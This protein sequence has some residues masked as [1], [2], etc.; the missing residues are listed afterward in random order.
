MNLI[1]SI[2]YKNMFIE[3]DFITLCS[4]YIFHFSFLIRIYGA[5]EGEL[6]REQPK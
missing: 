6:I 1:K 5:W 4:F 2:N 3:S